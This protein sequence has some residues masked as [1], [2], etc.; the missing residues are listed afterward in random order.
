MTTNTTQRLSCALPIFVPPLGALIAPLALA[1][2]VLVAIPAAAD[3]LRTPL[4]ACYLAAISA[5][6][7]D[8]D[9][10]A[11]TSTGFDGCERDHAMSAAK[12]PRADRL[13]LRNITLVRTGPTTETATTLIQRP[14]SAA[15][16]TQ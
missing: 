10:M 3:P 13:A 8:E 12:M 1:G 11:C 5:C 2:A 16:T 9:A 7:G 4:G 15:T 6:V 14:A